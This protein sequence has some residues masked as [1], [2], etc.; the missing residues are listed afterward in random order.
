MQTRKIAFDTFHVA[1][2]RGAAAG[3]KANGV[4]S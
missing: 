4:K 2:Y 3:N 1:K